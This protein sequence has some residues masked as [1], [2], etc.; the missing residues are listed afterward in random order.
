[1]SKAAIMNLQDPRNLNR[2]IVGTL[3]NV[4]TSSE[5][6]SEQIQIAHVKNPERKY[7]FSFQ[8]E[9]WHTPPIEEYILLL[10]GT[11]KV[12]VDND[13]IILKPMQLLKIPPRIPHKILDYSTP[14]HY[15]LLRTPIS[16]EDTKVITE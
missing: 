7:F 10:E 8:V 16:T 9:H 2:W 13:I 6:H 5:F 11:L 3:P 14:L 12:R 1:M 15:F 4:S